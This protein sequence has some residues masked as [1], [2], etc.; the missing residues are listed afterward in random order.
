MHKRTFGKTVHFTL[1][2]I[3]VSQTQRSDF[4]LDRAQREGISRAEAKIRNFL[5]SYGASPRVYPKSR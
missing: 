4:H 5:E 3:Q 2:T 1:D